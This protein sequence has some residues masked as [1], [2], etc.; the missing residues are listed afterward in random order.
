MLACRTRPHGVE[1]RGPFAD[2]TPVTFRRFAAIFAALVGVAATVG[3]GG[4][5]TSSTG[6]DYSTAAHSASPT[7]VRHHRRRRHRAAVHH[8][9]A[10]HHR[11]H[12]RRKAA[13]VVHT[14][15]VPRVDVPDPAL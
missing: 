6:G 15:G 12:R 7:S 5:T 8:K 9:R 3:C 13:T 14:A 1:G 4:G 11:H 2:A 10:A